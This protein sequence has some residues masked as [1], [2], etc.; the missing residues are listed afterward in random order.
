MTKAMIGRKQ[1]KLEKGRIHK[2]AIMNHCDLYRDRPLSRTNDVSKKM[3]EPFWISVMLNLRKNKNV[4]L[5]VSQ[6]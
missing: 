6:R 4:K 2:H 3:Y 5:L 1:T